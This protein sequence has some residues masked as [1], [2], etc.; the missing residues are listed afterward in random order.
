MIT[1]VINVKCSEIECINK[2]EQICQGMQKYSGNIENMALVGLIHDLEMQV[3]AL[4]SDKK[5]AD[6][7][8]TSDDLTFF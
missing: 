2:I 3:N 1:D 4:K 8:N 7:D 5:T 6:T